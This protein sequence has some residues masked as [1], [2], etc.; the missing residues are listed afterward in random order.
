MQSSPET[1]PIADF[2]KWHRE[3]E[4]ILNPDFQRGSVWRDTAKSYLVDTILRGMPVP[5]ILF[6]TKIDRQTKQIVREVVDGQQRLRA[7]LAFANNELTL[8][9]RTREFRGMKY[10]DLD[11]DDQDRFLAYKLTTEQLVNASNEDVLEIFVRINSYTV[12]V[13]PPELRHAKFDTDFKWSIVETK[14]RLTSFWALGSLSERERVR[15][16]DSSLVAE[17]Y[18]LL[19]NGVTDGGQNKITQ[20]YERHKDGFPEQGLVEERTLLVAEIVESL[21]A[22]LAR[23]PIVGPPHILM[24]FAAVAH[25]KF[26]LPPGQLQDDELERP[27]DALVDVASARDNVRIINEVLSQDRPSGRWGNFWTVSKSTTQRISSRRARFPIYVQALSPQPV[28]P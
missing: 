18:G 10:D 27:S 12:P 13:N 22:D 5:K 17:M 2:L 1:Y 20:L 6:R 9:T 14:K 15:M 21:L 19:I 7:I 26:G 23:E 25:A 3:R 16:L 4:L 28:T 24:L 11:P 8:G